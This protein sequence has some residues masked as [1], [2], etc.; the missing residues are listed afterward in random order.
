MSVS[1]RPSLFGGS[2]AGGVFLL[3]LI[4]GLWSELYWLFFFWLLILCVLGGDYRYYRYYVIHLEDPP[5][6]VET[7]ELLKETKLNF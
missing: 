2:L 1:Y 5:T 3:F 7:D 4:I 6:T